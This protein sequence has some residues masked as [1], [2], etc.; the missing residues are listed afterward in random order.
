MYPEVRFG[1]IAL[2]LLAAGVAL[3]T[4]QR[5]V[6]GNLMVLKSWTATEGVIVAMP[7][8]NHVEVSIGPG[9]DAHPLVVSPVDTLG[10]GLRKKVRVYLDPADPAK[11]RFGGVLQMWFWPSMLALAAMLFLV[12]TITVVRAGNADQVTAIGVIRLSA[13]PPPMDTDIRVRP[14]ASEWK[15]PLFWSL[16]GVA[17]LAFGVFSSE[18]RM[19]ARVGLSLIGVLVILFAWSVSLTSRTLEITAD[20]NGIRK[21]SAFGWS[22][23]RWDQIGRFERLITI[24]ETKKRWLLY[25]LP[26]PGRE[27]E[28]YVLSNK[29][30][31]PLMHISVDMGPMGAMRRLLELCHER[32]GLSLERKTERIPDF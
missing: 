17:A 25:D 8:E 21:T 3:F 18:G 31:W 1:L 15:T 5:I 11:A 7:A 26:F 2:A 12:F 4:V 14:P 13:P 20:R 27:S 23:I 22:E 28:N 24:P 6:T 10:L 32:T 9:S 19:I 16:L 30:G 29:S